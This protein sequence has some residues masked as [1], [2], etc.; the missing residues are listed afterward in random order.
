MEQ[1]FYKIRL[2]NA[3]VLGPIDLERVKLFILNGAITGL[4]SARLYPTGEWKDVNKFPEIAELLL[5]KL[6]GS[7]KAEENGPSG[8]PSLDDIFSNEPR[9]KP[10]QQGSIQQISLALSGISNTDTPPEEPAL[11]PTKKSDEPLADGTPVLQEEKTSV[12]DEATYVMS[13]DNEPT[14]VSD[15]FHKFEAEREKTATIEREKALQE[16]VSLENEVV[17]AETVFIDKKVAQEKTV[18]LEKPKK[19]STP[20]EK[21]KKLY[22][23][24]IIVVA[25]LA[26]FSP[27]ESGQKSNEAERPFRVEMPVTAEKSDPQKSQRT[28]LEGLPFYNEDTVEGYKKAARAFGKAVTEDSN[29]VR[30]ICLLASAYMNLIDVLN[31]DETYFTVVTR[32]IEMA[33]AK[34]VDLPEMVVADVELYLILGN[35]DAAMNRIIEFTKTHPFGAEMFYYLA[36]SFYQKAQFAESLKYLNSIDPKSWFSPRVPFLYG[37]VFDKNGQPEDALK[38]FLETAKRSPAHVKAKVHLAELYYRNDNLPEAGKYADFVIS[39]SRSASH[40]ELSKAHYYRARMLTGASK[41]SEALQDL[42]IALKHAPENT[43]IL[44]E[45][46]TLKARAGEKVQ[47]AQEK[48]KMFHYMALGEKFFR[49]GNYKEAMSNF[50]TARETQFKDPLPLLRI[51]DVFKKMGDL[52]AAKNSMAK[53]VELAP[54]RVDLYPKYVSLLIDAYEFETAARQMELFKG[55]NPPVSTVDKLQG[56]LYYKQDRLR[57]ALIYYKRALSSTNVD[58]SVYISY[59]NV[60]FKGNSFRDAAFYY[61]LALR[62]DPYNVEATIGVG[63]AFSELENLDRGVE[64]IQGA[65][66][67]SPHK[68]ALLNGIAELYLRK[69]NFEQAL[70]F[71][72]NALAT[73]PNYVLAHK[74]RGDSYVAQEKVKEALDAYLTFNNLSPLD[75]RGRIERYRI[76]LKK[77][78]LKSGKDEIQKVIENYPRYPGA[79]YMLG[80]LY[81]EGQNFPSALEAAMHEISIN[82]GYVPAYVLAATVYNSAREYGKA[83]EIINKALKI[84]PNFVPALIQAGFANHMMKTYAA[85]R[86]LYERA[87]ALDSGNPQIHKRLGALYFDLGDR[88]KAQ[89]HFRAYLDLY[90]N[91]PDRN[92]VENALNGG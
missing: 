86:A 26:V 56:D 88:A 41:I 71:A 21:K 4:E 36:L 34:G 65:L 50:V 74:I 51:A 7:L 68:A 32:L 19:S 25:V 57:E 47:G 23:A 79:Y 69:G 24:A 30:A 64:Y 1:R 33:R 77:L 58:A 35:P 92:E 84:D 29:N 82:R 83:L 52:Q 2:S 76:F 46:Y 80:E 49:D 87:L 67:L 31:R 8:E 90:P 43:D 37:L 89:Q 63:K 22:L 40:E 27:E 53:A 13:P 62:F 16:K 28:Y 60:M 3:R 39:N 73:D 10:E 9:I 70:K 91:A 61:G 5:Q 18:F 6:E 54:T 78:D 12:H 11:S 81:R 55:L 45:Y 66:Q 44:L 20:K 85:A 14:L 59:A 15:A 72:Q 75:P 48:A 38:A 17:K 42:E